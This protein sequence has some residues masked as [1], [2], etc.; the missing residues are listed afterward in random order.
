MTTSLVPR[1]N[2]KRTDGLQIPLVRGLWRILSFSLIVKVAHT[3]QPLLFHS[4]CI[5]ALF[6]A[7]TS[8]GKRRVVQEFMIVFA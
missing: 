8:S 6:C 5:A 7:I 2:P 1:R 4:E 3:R